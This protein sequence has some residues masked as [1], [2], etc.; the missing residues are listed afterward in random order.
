[1]SERTWDDETLSAW[2]D[3]EVGPSGEPPRPLDSLSG[4]DR[5]RFEALGATQ[6][7]AAT[8]TEPLAVADRE[9]LLARALEEA[10]GW[11]QVVGGDELARRRA[12]RMADWRWLAPV[13]AIVVALLVAV[14][15]LARDDDGEQ[16][17]AG[18]PAPRSMATE[19]DL[20]ATSGG[21]GEVTDDAGAMTE[22]S[23]DAFT[24]APP[25]GVTDGGDLG[26]VDDL[27]TLLDRVRP[28]TRARRSAASSSGTGGAAGPG[29]D[30]AGDEAGG[31]CQTEG[32]AISEEPVRLV[33]MARLQWQGT[34]AVVLA[35]AVLDEQG[36]ATDRS[37]VTVLAEGDCR[38]LASTEVQSGR[39]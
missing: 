4:A 3:G 7:V 31:A 9:V 32:A 30:T 35:F 27:P 8:P 16:T 17:V 28:D 5:A 33:Y 12:R 15:L 29:T 34:P 37:L 14:P 23:A 10:A 26:A 21:G 39:R 25:P 2:L 1:M 19:D 38:L 22:Y 11:G 24:A 18:G 6:Q 20:G 13:A 36:E